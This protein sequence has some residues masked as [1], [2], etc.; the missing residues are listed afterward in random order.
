MVKDR[1][2]IGRKISKGEGG[3]RGQ[4][5]AGREKSGRVETAAWR[6]KYCRVREKKEKEGDEWG[7]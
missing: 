2:G 6:G 1:V 4:W 7:P 5:Q 3:K